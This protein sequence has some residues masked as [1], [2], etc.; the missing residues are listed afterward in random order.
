VDRG[1]IAFAAMVVI[2]VVAAALNGYRHYEELLQQYTH[3]HHVEAAIVGGA[4]SSGSR[5]LLQGAGATFPLPQLLEW[6]R[7]FMETHPHIVVSYRGVGSGAGQSMFFERTI[8]FAGSDPP[9]T[10]RQWLEYRGLVM[11]VPY[12]LGAVVVTYNLPGFHG[13]LN[14]SGRVLALIYSGKIVYWD[15]PRI[16]RLNPGYRFPHK[17]IVVVYRADAS[18]TQ[19]IFTLF[20]HKSAPRLWPWSLVSKVPKYPVMASGRARGGKGNPGVAQIV[21][22]TPYS[23][24]FVEWGYALEKH[25]PIAAIENSAGVFVKP[26]IESIEAAAREAFKHLP[27]DPRADFSDDLT[28]IVYAPGRESYPIASWTHLILW[29]RYPCTKA[30]ALAQFLTWIAEEGY[31]HMVPGYAPIP[32]PM[33]GLLLKAAHIIVEGCVRG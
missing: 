1:A 16:Q 17:P 3:I 13:T 27:K 2:V 24:G 25:M 33:R 10:H 11:Q 6:I 20:L 9:L 12:L 19:Y 4:S 21:L 15:D 31:R 14:L 28:Y 7:L 8:D 22:S 29:T 23:I 26:S 30:R 32:E 18:G 5:V